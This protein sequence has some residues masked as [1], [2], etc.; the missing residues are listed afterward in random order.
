MRSDDDH[1][2]SDHFRDD[3]LTGL[4]ASP[5]R[6]PCKYLYDA[7]GSE[8]FEAIC[9]TDAY[10]PTR[11]E[12][13]LLEQFGAQMARAIGPRAVL[14]EFGSG[15]GEK[16]WRLLERLD[17]PQAYIPVE[18][19]ASALEASTARLREA[20]PDLAIRP[21]VADYTH[22]LDLPVPEGRAPTV[23][24]PGSTIG[25]FP[26]QK[27]VEFL[28]QIAGLVGPGGGLL[29]GVDTRKDPAVLHRAYNDE[30]GITEAF[31]LNLLERANRELDADFEPASFRHHA[32]YHPLEG[33]IESYLVSLEA[34][35]VRVSG[36]VF[37]FD[38]GEAIHTEYSYKYNVDEFQALASDVGFEPVQVWT[39]P[40]QWFSVH[41]LVAR[42]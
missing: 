34:Q 38:R 10:Y 3:V 36:E 2:A 6:L 29:I 32:I 25:N 24:F 37:R 30:E 1:G 7:R 20:F 17:S 33:R 40:K 14:V 16:T 5:K 23:F 22:P 26:R 41:Y 9:A 21:V 39:D 42:G 12:I 8:L 15:S 13:G 27:A 28:G 35:S 4:G 31:N 18:I 11:T 19:S